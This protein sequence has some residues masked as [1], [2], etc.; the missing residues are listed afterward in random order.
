MAVPIRTGL[1]A[2]QSVF[3]RLAMSQVLSFE[4]GIGYPLAIH[5]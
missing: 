5:N 1:M 4:L 2:A 3:G